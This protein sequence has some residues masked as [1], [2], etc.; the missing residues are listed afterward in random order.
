MYKM[1][2]VITVIIIIIIIIIIIV[3]VIIKVTQC[4]NTSNARRQKHVGKVECVGNFAPIV[5]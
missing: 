2:A 4:Y 1:R 3:S 5:L